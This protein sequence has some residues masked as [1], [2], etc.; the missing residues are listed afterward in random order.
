MNP[1]IIKIA[2]FSI[3]QINETCIKIYAEDIMAISP[4]SSNC[5]MIMN[6]KV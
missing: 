1:E 3:I 2:G 5:V 4:S 6:K